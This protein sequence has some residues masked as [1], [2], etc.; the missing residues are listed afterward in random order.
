MVEVEKEMV[1]E[2]EEERRR[3]TNLSNMPLS[4]SARESPPW[5]GGEA[6]LCPLG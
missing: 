2:E 1:V 6:P 3:N 5:P 4:T